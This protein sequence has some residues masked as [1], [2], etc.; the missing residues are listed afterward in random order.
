MVIGEMSRKL[1]SASLAVR[2]PSP[3]SRGASSMYAELLENL[4]NNA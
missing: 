4:S 1:S 2:K 3:L